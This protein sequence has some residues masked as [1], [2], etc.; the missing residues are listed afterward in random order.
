LLLTATYEVVVR[1][2]Q[3]LPSRL[4][5]EPFWQRT[6]HTNREGRGYIKIK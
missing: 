1:Q 2:A 4:R 3:G 5:G 6:D